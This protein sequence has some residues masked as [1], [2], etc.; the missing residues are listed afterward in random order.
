MSDC[1]NSSLR[2]DILS[3]IELIE[4]KSY[5][6]KL[7]FDFKTQINHGQLK[8]P[9]INLSTQQILKQRSNS[10]KNG[11]SFY[12]SLQGHTCRLKPTKSAKQCVG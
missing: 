7:T 9:Q 1:L 8:T 4:L 6:L 11:F 10:S 12:T 3:L 5:K 2:Y